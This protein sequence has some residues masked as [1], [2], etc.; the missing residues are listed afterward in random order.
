MI[1]RRQVDLA[2]QIR[3]AQQRLD[4]GAE[5]QP[6]PDDGVVQRLDANPIARHEDASRPAVP[7]GEAEHAPKAADGR[8]APLLVRVDDHFGVG[9]CIEAM[10]GGFQFRAK[11]AKI[12]DFPVEDDPH[13]PILVVNRLVPGGQVDD[14]Q[15]PHSERYTLVDQHSFV[16]RPAMP[17]HVAHAVDQLAAF[18]ERERVG[19]RRRF[20]ESGYAAH[21]LSRCR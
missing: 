9:R 12:V 1:E 19:D 14:A 18:I 16:V 21:K 8:G 20:G 17:D 15:A 10:T 2:R 4:F 7:D 3:R 6:P 11:L 13:R 5:I